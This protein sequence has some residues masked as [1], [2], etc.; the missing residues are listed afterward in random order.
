MARNPE[1]HSEPRMSAKERK[2]WSLATGRDIQSVGDLKRYQAETGK[3]IVEKGFKPKAPDDGPTDDEVG[4]MIE[5]HREERFS[6]SIDERVKLKPLE[7]C[8]VILPETPEEK[9]AGGI[10][11]P[12]GAKEKPTRGRVVA[13]GPGRWLSS[14][15]K[16]VPVD[17]KVGDDVL[18]K[19]Y[20]G[21]EID[22]DGESYWMVRESDVLVAL[23][24]E[25]A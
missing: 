17:L 11:F 3:A 10:I 21:N 24:A 20:T 6:S 9:S 22:V 16:H 18:F 14:L 25:T 7:D 5:K 8:V 2:E 12:E 23:E 13:V 19:Q 4:K 15:G 1:H